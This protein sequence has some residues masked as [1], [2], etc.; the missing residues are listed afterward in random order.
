MYLTCFDFGSFQVQM[1]SGVVDFEECGIVLEV[2]DCFEEEVERG[3]FGVRSH[4][5]KMLQEVHLRNLVPERLME[6][7]VG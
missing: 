2:L 3:T 7:N 5:V 4:F 1:I 6:K